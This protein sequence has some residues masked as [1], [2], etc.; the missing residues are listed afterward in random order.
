MQWRARAASTAGVLLGHG[1]SSKVSTT[2]PDL[3]K[4][5]LL[6]CSKP[7]PGPPVVSICTVRASP[8]ASGL[9]GQDTGCG[10][11]AGGAAAG[12]PEVDGAW[13]RV[14]APAGA[15]GFAVGA[16]DGAAGATAPVATVA[17]GSA[18]GFAGVVGC[19]AGEL[20][21]VADAFPEVA[22]GGDNKLVRVSVT[23]AK[24]DSTTKVQARIT[25]MAKP[26]ANHLLGK[27]I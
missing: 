1:P 19:L 2:S 20:A 11:G 21:A 22:A 27:L 23:A 16:G 18:G 9:P 13:A 17:T 7:K 3:R 4:S 26:F 6:K 5:W 12:V 15:A 10:A 24:I 14:A 8:S 25:R